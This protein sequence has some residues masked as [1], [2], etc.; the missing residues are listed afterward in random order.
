MLHLYRATTGQLMVQMLASAAER[1]AG[2]LRFG[3][4][5]VTEGSSRLGQQSCIKLVAVSG[6][7]R[8]QVRESDVGVVAIGSVAGGA[9]GHQDRAGQDSGRFEQEFITA[10]RGVRF[11]AVGAASP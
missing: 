2:S 1:L 6:D 7:A 11:P 5:A 4:Q 9:G 3:S 10:W 8:E